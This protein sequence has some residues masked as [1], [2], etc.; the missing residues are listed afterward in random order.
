MKLLSLRL[1]NVRR[2]TAPVEI[3]DIGPGLNVLAAPNEQGKSTLF[4]ALHALFFYEARSWKQKEAASLAPHAG[5]NPEISADVEVDGTRYRLTKVFSARA[6][7]R[8]VSVHRGA[9]LFKQGE[10]AES[11]IATLMKPPKDGGP[12]GL[13][14]VRQGLTALRGGKEDE[15][16]AAR[17]DVLSSVAG[18]IKDVTGGRHMERLRTAVRTELETYL[19]RSGTVKKHGPLSEARAAVTDLEAQEAALVAKVAEFRDKLTERRALQK[20]RA[21]LSDPVAAEERATALHKA[22]AAVTAAEA[23]AGK[24]A[25]ADEA[26]RTAELVLSAHRD[27]IRRIDE[28]ITE[29]RAAGTALTESAAQLAQADAACATARHEMTA[30]QAEE[31]TARA[32]RRA[33]EEHRSA[34]ETAARRQKDAQRR[35]EIA[36]RIEDAQTDTAEAAR[37]RKAIAQAPTSAQMDQLERAWQ[38][39]DA[40]RRARA[41]AAAAITLTATPEA[42]AQITLD[43]TPLPPGERIALPDGGEIALAGL[44]TL[45]VHPAE[46]RDSAAMARA[47][48]ALATALA[49]TGHPDVSAA[50]TAAAARQ[51]AEANLRDAEARLRIVAPGG[52]SALLEEHAA[53]PADLPEAGA[54]GHALPSLEEAET[55]LRHA[56]SAHD[57]AYAKLEGARAALEAKNGDTRELRARH[58]AAQSRVERASEALPD[59]SAAEEEQAALRLQTTELTSALDTAKQTAQTLREAAPDLEMARLQAQRAEAVETQTSQRLTELGNRLSALEALIAHDADLAVE[60]K[61]QEVVERRAAAQAHAAQ[62]ETEMRVLTRLDTALSEAQKSAHDTYIGPIHNELRP[63]LRMVLPDADLMLDAE[64]VLP[65]GLVRAAGEDSYEQLSGGTQEQIALLVRLAFAR[66]LA[67][68]GT[69]APVIL[70]DAIV[71]TDDDRIERMFNALTQQASDLQI[72]VLSCRQR[73]FRGLGGQSLTIRPVAEGP[74]S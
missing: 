43:G 65:T 7:Q 51:T 48:E 53:L 64:S 31:S 63:L 27:R 3:T 35:R 20:E 72:I 50:R 23:H 33:A 59:L 71:Y 11:W 49:A 62:V 67:K 47:E 44:G 32:A 73:V 16:L 30:A 54:E 36:T 25:R 18:E 69:P 74:V 61:L 37:A 21:S 22:R 2:F 9:H 5:G 10:E 13:L 42:A 8:H 40:L 66:L 57:T 56:Q 70:D 26:E 46:H 28:Q 24:Q 38:A 41:A 4:E 45:R 19:T 17:R 55:A 15:T 34:V 14:W 29:A 1:N 58:D 12:S 52:L 6:A 39:R 68:S 60:E